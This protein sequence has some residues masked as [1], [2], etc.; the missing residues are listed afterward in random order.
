MHLPVDP[1]NRFIVTAN[2]GAGSVGVFPIGQD[3]SLG[4]RTDLATLP[5]E[6]GPN[7]EGTG[8]RIRTTARPTPPGVCPGA[9]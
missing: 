5:G 7:R 6:P 8:E 3:G 1:R 4:A 2:Y 9:R